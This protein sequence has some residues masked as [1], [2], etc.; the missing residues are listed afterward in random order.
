MTQSPHFDISAAVVRQLGEELVS[1]EVTAIIELVKNCYDADASY[2]SIVVNTDQW[3][4]SDDSFF[5]GTKGSITIEDDGIGMD[6]TDIQRGWLTISLSSKRQMKQEKRT[7]PKGRIPLGDKGLGRLSTQRLG[8]Q[9]DLITRKEHSNEG[10]HIAFNWNDFKENVPLSS[11]PIH[12]KSFGEDGRKKGTKL[13]ISGMRDPRVWMG[14]ARTELIRKL[15]QLIFPF[16]DV[17]PF[18][19]YMMINGQRIDLT[20]VAE[21]VREAAVARFAFSYTNQ[22][23]SVKGRIRLS[24]LKALGAENE[25]MYQRLLAEDQGQEFFA[26]LTSPAN[27]YA[28]PNAKYDGAD[29]WFLSFNEIRELRSLGGVAFVKNVLQDIPTILENTPVNKV[30][31]NNTIADP[32]KFYAELDEFALRGTDL[33]AIDAVFDRNAEFSQFVKNQAGVRIFR[34]GFGIRPYGL[35]G[36]DWLNLGGSQTSGRSFYGLRPQNVIGYVALSEG[37]NQNLREKTDREGLIGSPYSNNFF[38]LLDEAVK[39]IN[40]AYNNLRRS[41]NEYKRI[42]SQETSGFETVDAPLKEMRLASVSAEK[43]HQQTTHLEQGIELIT[44]SVR[45]VTDRVDREPLFASQA[46]SELMPLLKNVNTVLVESRDLVKELQLLLPKA[47]RLGEIADYLEPRISALEAQLE[48]FSELAGLGLTAEVLSH[49]IHTV[50]DRLASRTRSVIEVIKKQGI[51]STEFTTYTEYVFSAVGT[52]RKQLSHLAPSLRYVREKK[53][54]IEIYTFFKEIQEFYSARFED[55]G[56]EI[57]L[58]EPFDNFNIL[59]NRGRF[60][61]IVDNLVLNSEY[62][63]KEATRAEKI[64]A[65]T[66]TISSTSP[67]ISV[68]DNGLGVEPSVERQLF[69]PFV[70]AKPRNQGRGLGLFIVQQLLD[71]IGGS[72][73]LLPYRNQY[74]R[75]YI[76]QID[77]TGVIN[78][79]RGK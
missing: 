74:S 59:I 66:I 26:F 76:F 32:G 45:V 67:F 63:L 62:W 6:F 4:T 75:R 51:K 18:R 43:L 44:Q 53:D 56:I 31:H 54:V 47:R 15:S 13:V 73:S 55:T 16:G 29:G 65:P 12:L 27:R 69:Q 52:L 48:E 34:N 19:V 21:S 77:L 58:K 33:D 25:E 9:L 20:T 17:R 72:I 8:D 40:L 71:S 39:I 14:D 61:Q 2:A 70:T 60:T 41:Y 37:D 68:E 5:V 22:T 28:M 3:L 7:T 42:R 57:V 49:E 23:L 35:D 46:E 1:D 30:S 10:Y 50:A 11:V 78:D 64:S 24:R 79:T 38:L 36:R